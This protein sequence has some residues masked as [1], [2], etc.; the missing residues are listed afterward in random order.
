MVSN[1]I[2]TITFFCQPV[3]RLMTGSGRGTSKEK[4]IWFKTE[5]VQE[6]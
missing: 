2:K 5:N 3:P 4:K 1:Y 6:K